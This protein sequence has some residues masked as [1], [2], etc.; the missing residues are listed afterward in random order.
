VASRPPTGEAAP[1]D[2]PT[3]KVALGTTLVLD[4]GV[5]AV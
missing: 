1:M 5:T 2:D 3:D 4:G